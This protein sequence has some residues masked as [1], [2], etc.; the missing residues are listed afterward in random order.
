[1]GEGKVIPF[2]RPATI[3]TKRT[4]VAS[5]VSDSGATTCT[6]LIE[7]TSRAKPED[8]AELVAY[9]RDLA[10]LLESDAGRSL[11]EEG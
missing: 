8:R 9:I 10:N 4:P 7:T 3:S 6:F 5:W 11:F 1:M 2:E